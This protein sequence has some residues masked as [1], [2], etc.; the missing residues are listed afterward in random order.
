MEHEPDPDPETATSALFVARAHMVRKGQSETP[1]GSPT[2]VARNFL[3][4]SV[5]ENVRQC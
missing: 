4:K 5:F 2:L 1:P 3:G